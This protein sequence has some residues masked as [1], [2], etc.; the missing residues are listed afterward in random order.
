M[1]ATTK[2]AFWGVGLNEIGRFLLGQLLYPFFFSLSYFG[3]YDGIE[4]INLS[5]VSFWII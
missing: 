3:R 4:G 5:K 1:Q 2:H